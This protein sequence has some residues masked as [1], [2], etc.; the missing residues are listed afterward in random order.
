MK[1]NTLLFHLIGIFSNPPYGIS[2]SLHIYTPAEQK[3]VDDSLRVSKHSAE[4]KVK[5]DG[6]GL[7]W[8]CVW[9]FLFILV[10][11]IICS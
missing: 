9:L 5:Y 10:L 7:T 2:V 11:D 8:V 4:M 1:F 3:V 6:C